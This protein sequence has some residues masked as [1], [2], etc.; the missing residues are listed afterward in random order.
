M[1]RANL[2]MFGHVV[3]AARDLRLALI[4]VGHKQIVFRDTNSLL[5]AAV[6]SRAARF[7]KDPSLFL[8]NLGRQN[9]NAT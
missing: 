9:G 7:V 3:G 1:R 4:D 6:A 8:S 5:A 2:P